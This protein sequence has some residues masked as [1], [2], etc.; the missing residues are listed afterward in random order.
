MARTYFRQLIEALSAASRLQPAI[1]HP[2][3]Q[4]SSILLD[5]SGRLYICGWSEISAKEMQVRLWECIFSC[6]EILM[7]MVLSFMPFYRKYSA[8]DTYYKFICP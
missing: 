4:A 6:G 5:E 3:L 2:N 8:T 1:I 7:C